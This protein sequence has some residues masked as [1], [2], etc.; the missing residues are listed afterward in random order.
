MGMFGSTRTL[1]SLSIARLVPVVLVTCLPLGA[2]GRPPRPTSTEACAG[3]AQI[4]SALQNLNGVDY[5]NPN[6]TE[7][8]TALGTLRTGV[9]RV[10]AG[11]HLSQN[12]ELRQLGGVPYLQSF[13]THV[14]TLMSQVAEVHTSPGSADLAQI[15]TQVAAQ[16][17]E[18]QRIA[19]SVNGC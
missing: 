6:V 2:C 8:H 3:R 11:V 18:G 1:R 9:S 14:R 16:M 12:V 19:D 15:Q 7:L 4:E 5:Q 17:R 13:S 10:E